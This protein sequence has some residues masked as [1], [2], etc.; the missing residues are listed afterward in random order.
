MKV[1]VIGKGGR[2]H[3][4]V[5]KLSQSAR[6]SQLL[7]APG[8]AGTARIASNVPIPESDIEGL[9]SFALQQD[10]DFTVVGPEAPLAD[11]IVDRFQEAGLSIF[12]PSQAAARIESSKS[13]AKDLMLRAGVPT[14]HAEV[15]HDFNAA[16]KYVET[17]SPPVVIKADGLA[18][19]K[20]VV[21]ADTTEKAVSALRD[22]MVDLAFGSAG[23]TVLVEEYLQGPELSVFAFVDGERIS[24]L[25][26]AVDYKRVGEG[27]TGP[28]TGGMGAYS[29]P[30]SVLWNDE[31][32]CSARTDIMEPVVAAIATEG[33]P[34]V[35]ILYAGL[36]LTRDGLQVIE[37]NCRLGDPETQVVLPRIESDLLELMLAAVAGNVN[38]VPLRVTANSCVGV[39]VASG[40]YPGTYETGFPV[41][42]LDEELDNVTV[43]H[44]GTKLD[45][46]EETVTDGGRV[47]TVSGSGPT[48]KDAR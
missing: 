17:L 21:V 34:Y 44:A 37:F 38:D 40:G 8:N 18:A 29:P 31:V 26:A 20:G 5:W 6:I 46:N 19:G 45:E 1:L 41:A 43:F 33:C 16:R 36:M 42:G 25:V 3:A 4:I 39:V 32:E 48:R 10:I 15:F 30:L 9:L 47:L 11:G 35:G 12:G 22:Q 13:F 27:D 23:E 14:A 2:E 24:P 7:C 28:N